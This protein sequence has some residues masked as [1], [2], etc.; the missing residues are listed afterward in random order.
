MYIETDLEKL[1]AAIMYVLEGVESDYLSES[2]IECLEQAVIE[3]LYT[4]LIVSELKHIEKY[5]RPITGSLYM[6][7]NEGVAIYN[8]ILVKKILA[9]PNI[10]E[11]IEYIS[12]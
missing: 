7:E 1:F 5:G 9:L 8:G 2:D 3:D 6:G 12:R 11:I 4:S 10:E